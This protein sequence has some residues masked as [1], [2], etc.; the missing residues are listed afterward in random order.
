MSIIRKKYQTSV[1]VIKEVVKSVK[2]VIKTKAR[3]VSPEL[4][5]KRILIC[6]K[7]PHYNGTTCSI[8]KC[9]ANWKT[10]LEGSSCPI[11]KW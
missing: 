11:N 5:I 4:T 7:C 6:Q 8:C 2:G 3:K 10:M 1:T 9:R